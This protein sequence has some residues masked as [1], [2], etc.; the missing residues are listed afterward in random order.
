MTEREIVDWLDDHPASAETRARLIRMLVDR[1]ATW[2]DDEAAILSAYRRGMIKRE[3]KAA[4]NWLEPSIYGARPKADT[5]GRR[6]LLWS[7]LLGGDFTLDW[8]LAEYLIAWSEAAGVESEKIL[9][10]FR[11][12][13]ER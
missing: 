9:A 7:L 13:P 8:Y 11:T 3:H 4:Q 2:S 1:V 5:E 12:C 6:H 10:D